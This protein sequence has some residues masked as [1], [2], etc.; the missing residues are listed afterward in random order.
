MPAEGG[1]APCARP[2]GAK[3][4]EER[5]PGPLV[6]AR[7]AAPAGRR[8]RRAADRRPDVSPERAAP[9]VVGGREHAPGGKQ[10]EA[11][12]G[13]PTASGIAAAHHR[14]RRS[15]RGAV[16]ARGPEH[17]VAVDVIL[18]ADRDRAA[19]EA[20]ASSRRG[21]SR[22]SRPR[23]CGSRDG[24][25]PARAS[26]SSRS[27]RR[28]S[29]RAHRSCRDSASPPRCG[30]ARSTYWRCAPIPMSRCAV[31]ALDARGRGGLRHRADVAI[32]VRGR[33][34]R[35]RV[36]YDGEGASRGANLTGREVAQLLLMRRP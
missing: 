1:C 5:S 4:G 10:D 25:I 8:P 16:R 2:S 11:R 28:G 31:S 34:R 9:A 14:R 15:P 20:I 6:R 3:A 18:A 13:C 36:R 26:G 21:V 19:V 35:G 27:A 17:E 24:R 7:S 33:C 30:L 29:P 22:S 23:F 32:L 12:S